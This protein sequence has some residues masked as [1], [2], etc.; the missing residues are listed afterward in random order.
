VESFSWSQTVTNRKHFKAA[1]GKFQLSKT[2]YFKA[3]GGKFQLV[4]ISH[5]QSIL[6]QQVESLSWSQTVTNRKHFKAAG[7]KFQL[8]TNRVI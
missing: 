3:A 5:K 2:E 1:G 4:T 7:G 6:K 8:V